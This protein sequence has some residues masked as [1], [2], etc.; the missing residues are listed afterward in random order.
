MN[1]LE[2]LVNRCNKM[3]YLLGLCSGC[4]LELVRDERMPNFQKLPLL[5]LLTRVTNGVDELYF[6]DKTKE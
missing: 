6:K 4:L 2:E 1:Q 3:C 5:E